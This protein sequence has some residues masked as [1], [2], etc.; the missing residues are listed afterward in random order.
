[1]FLIP[2]LFYQ[3]PCNILQNVHTVK[4]CS[5]LTYIAL[6]FSELNMLFREEVILQGL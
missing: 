6:H 3:T 2:L 4:I 5:F 1:M